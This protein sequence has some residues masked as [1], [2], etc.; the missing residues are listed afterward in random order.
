MPPDLNRLTAAEETFV[1]ADRALGMPID[2]QMLWRFDSPLDRAR[3]ET[4][5]RALGEGPLTRRL[6]RAK[7]PF[8]RDR[9]MAAEPPR[10]LVSFGEPIDGSD[11]LQWAQRCIDAPLD[12]E[13]GCAWRISAA[14][15]RDGGHVVSLVASHAVVDGSGFYAAVITAVTG[16]ATGRLPDDS[17][18]AA[19]VSKWADARD[20][21]LQI[22]S[23]VRGLVAA[24]R[25]VWRSRRSPDARS[26]GE[27]MPQPEPAA[28]IAP[29]ARAVA[30]AW[31]V[32]EFDEE[33]WVNAAKTFGGSSNSL[34]IALS[35]GLLES[36]G[37]ITAGTTIP[38]SMPVAERAPGDRRAIATIGATVAVPVAADRP[39][40]LQPIRVAVRDALTRATDPERDHTDIL[41]M[42]TPTI[43]LLP[44]AL[45]RR[46]ALSQPVSVCTCSN[47]G[48]LPS[49][50]STLGGDVAARTTARMLVRGA[51]VQQLRTAR[52]GITAWLTT[53]D[54]AATLSVLSMDPD[55]LPDTDSLQ[56][57]VIDEAAKWSL[58]PRFW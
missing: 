18:T 34:L 12:F 25:T 21:V 31:V 28:Q 7:V 51:D 22:V 10:P 54:G 3:L 45:L 41:R 57:A 56:Q 30:G 27:R 29:T 23:A 44:H 38:V 1:L 55:R 33:R 17:P 32:A 42:L 39:T 37:R 9:W 53:S 15:L 13:S 19:R 6:S 26:S 14:P 2:N 11:I 46:I 5:A 48:E 20:A 35:V 40:D 4:V 47:V 49:E 16:A 24:I 52:G 58:Q 43:R 50:V 36:V 8:A